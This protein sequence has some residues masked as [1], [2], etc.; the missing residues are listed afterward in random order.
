MFDRSSVNI[1]EA[2]NYPQEVNVTEKRAPT[3]ESVKILMEMETRV[4]DR[5]VKAFIFEDNPFN[6]AIV[7][8]KDPRTYRLCGDAVFKINGKEH[9]VEVEVDDFVVNN[10]LEAGKLLHAEFLKKLVAHFDVSE[11]GV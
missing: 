2:P 5:F 11:D 6:G 7:I 9:R 8:Y 3:D 1:V 4:R 10:K